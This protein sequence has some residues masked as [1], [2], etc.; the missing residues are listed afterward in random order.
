[1]RKIILF[2]ILFIAL[3]LDVKANT[4]TL[5]K[6]R[7]D[8]TYVYYY[9]SNLGKNRYLFATK[10]MFGNEA[11]Y[12]IELGKD[13]STFD[14]N[15]TNSF[16]GINISDYDLDYIKL[17][18]FYGYNYPGHNTDNF[19]LATQEI[20]WSKLSKASIRFMIG[21][22]TYN[23]IDLT[24]EKEEIY[25]LFRKH[26]IK[27]S[28]YGNT[29]DITM[30]EEVILEDN[31]NILS[32]F[33]SNNSNVIIDG[34]K[35]IIKDTFDSD[36]IKLDRPKYNNKSFFLYSALNSQKMM[37]VGDLDDY[38]ISLDVNLKKGSIEIN[39]LDKDNLNNTSRGEGTL[40]GAIYDLYDS[41]NNYID[42]FVTGKKNKIDN[43][44]IGK[45]YI[46][47]KKAS[48][49]Y[50]LD[51]N[52][53]E[54]E[55]TKDDL[56]KKIDVYEKV[57]ERKIELF[58]V[59]ASDST[60]I[61]TSENNALFE[62]YDKDDKL[63]GNVTTDNDGYGSIIL[64]YGVYTFKQITGAKDYYKVDDFIVNIDK[65]DS[66][67]IYKLLSDSEITS[68]VK[69]IKKDIDTLDNIVN[70]NIKF[71]IFDVKNNKYVS[72][73]LTYPSEIELD[74]FELNSDGIFITPDILHSGEYILY[75]VDD[76]MNN[77]LYNKKGVHFY[78]GEDSNFIN[79]ETYGQILEVEFFNK[80]V[81][82]KIIV[83][84]YGEEIIYKDNSYYYKDIMLDNVIFNLYAKDDVYE[85]SKLIYNKDD[86]IGEYTTDN[87]GRIVID[88]LPLGNYY[89]KEIKSN[90]DNVIDDNIYDISL[91]YKDQYTNK[92][93]HE[94]DIYNHINK[95]KVIIN[96]I[97]STTNEFISNTLIEIRDMYN[98]LVYKGYTDDNGQIILDDMPYG[99]YYISEIEA[100]TGYK[101]L[102]DNIYFKLDSSLYETSIYNER[103][104]I[105]ST[106][107]D[108]GI[109]NI[110][111]ITSIFIALFI[112]ICFIENKKVLI[113]TIIY[114]LFGISYFGINLYRY[115]YD[116]KK[117]SLAIDKVIN[118]E[119]VIDLEDKYSYTSVLEIP[120]INLKRGIVDINNKYNN[121]NDNIELIKKND[122]MMVLASHNG[123]YYNSYFG[124][125]H[126]MDL[127]DE[128]LFYDNNTLYKYL[129]S[130]NYKIKKNGTF[131]V[132]VDNNKKSIILI[133]CDEDSNDSQ[134][135]YVGYLKETYNY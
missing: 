94:I 44:K 30:G 1:M 82:G 27:P 59:F 14:Y 101:I 127:S 37:S 45:Y 84:K 2:F 111:L 105:P 104:N 48:T 57:I 26:N 65:S 128:I 123:N 76:Y 16:D 53:Y 106:G 100:S 108:M 39:K 116:N 135:V 15:Y 112:L 63:V 5:I 60:G 49:G 83:N 12:C 117:N 28:F 125:L 129:Y 31:N 113:I 56:N 8:D 24:K 66:R 98:N 61:L 50:E 124:N 62:V 64:P 91:E 97:D 32:M 42:S 10:Y 74:I 95:G 41:N 33:V 75:E 17:V 87:K 79:D 81:K 77:Y 67:P 96:K 90:Y 68:R 23:Y 72:F 115:I 133:T 13:I 107:I 11:V 6:N 71:K 40:D 93:N 4:V 132:Y 54:V 19:Y 69:I 126:K 122:N 52:N 3:T 25:S 92:I 55:I 43:L 130:D 9:D 121:A 134:V 34:N 86:L 46:K 18:S 36:S 102:D 73:K 80:I 35:L 109:K 99:E 29:V 7:Y 58:K 119:V 89:V 88:N 131:D 47:E 118:G 51:L 120:S 85:N 78:I 70:S 20:I 103:L 21:I 22:D 38:G 114:I 110:I